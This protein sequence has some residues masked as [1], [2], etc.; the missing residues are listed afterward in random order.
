MLAQHLETFAKLE[1]KSKGIISDSIHLDF[2]KHKGHIVIGGLVHGNEVGSLPG[3][4]QIIQNLVDKKISYGGKISF[5]LG[6]KRASIENKRFLEEDLN[7]SFSFSENKI[8]SYEKQRA[9]EIKKLLNTCDLFLD[10]HQ[11]NKPCLE[12]FYIFAMHSI[13]YSWAR[14]IGC[15]K[16]FVTRRANT[17]YSSEGMCSDEYVRTLNK[18]GITLELGQQGFFTNA[19]NTC[20]QAIINSMQLMDL[21]HLKK[22]HI[23]NLARKKNEL[24][25]LQMI[26]SEKFKTKQ[27]KLVKEFINLEKVTNGQLIGEFKQGQD[28]Y[29]PQDGYILFPQYP[30]RDENGFVIETLPSHIYTLAKDSNRLLK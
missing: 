2:N 29:A 12:P 10:F 3:I 16:I 9:E 7:R 15:C 30:M 22:R 27:S 26:Y 19:T 4:L 6:N 1:N 24:K 21:V 25:I 20:K 13:S 17:P 14:A 5:F 23:Q 8:K 28:F 11:T 18:P